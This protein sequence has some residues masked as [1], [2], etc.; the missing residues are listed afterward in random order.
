[1]T[2]DSTS[3]NTMQVAVIS[4]ARWSLFRLSKQ[5]LAAALASSGHEVVYV[6]PPVSVGSVV[7]DRTRWR[8]LVGSRVESP[9]PRLRVW[10]PIV[11]P[12]Q[13][14]RFGQSVNAFTMA[15]KLQR[16][17]PRLG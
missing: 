16:L 3:E 14:T 1:M 15:G 6:D 8:D 12:G 5:Y 13:N 17:L 11:L 4:P 9:H 10:H 2:A 7:R